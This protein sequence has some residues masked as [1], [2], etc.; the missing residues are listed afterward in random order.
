M[1]SEISTN[2]EST[3]NGDFINNLSNELSNNIENM[4]N[5][6]ISDA[7]SST[8]CTTSDI[9]SSVERLS[10]VLD[11]MEGM[12][13]GMKHTNFE[14]KKAMETMD[15]ASLPQLNLEIDNKIK[16]DFSVTSTANWFVIG[17]IVLII[18]VS[19]YYFTIVVKEKNKIKNGN[20]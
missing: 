11:S 16:E 17:F 20:N 4:S 5:Q 3:S 10:A 7:V 13:S 9:N 1:S 18:L 2:L 19:I 12:S 14:I 8:E 6:S 15:H